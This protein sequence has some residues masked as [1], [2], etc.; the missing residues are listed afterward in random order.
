MREAKK[1]LDTNI[2]VY[3]YDISAGAKSEAAKKIVL[4]LWDSGLGVIS[5]QVLHE[6]F[7]IITKKIPNPLKINTAK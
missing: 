2:L 5:T 3:A 1:F 6:F 7:V 4:D